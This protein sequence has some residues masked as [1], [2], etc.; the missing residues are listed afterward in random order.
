MDT[1]LDVEI[2]PDVEPEE[3][4]TKHQILAMKV[5]VAGGTRE[6][7]AIAADRH[8]RTVHRWLQEDDNFK[9]VLN[10]ALDVEMS[11][12]SRKLTTLLGDVLDLLRTQMLGGGSNLDQTLKGLNFIAK[13]VVS[14]RTHGELEERVR[15]LEESL[16]R[17]K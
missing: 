11:N 1:F 7:A 10:Q 12:A 3:V 4:L 14:F 5:L 9:R 8:V 15:V 16:F 13:H 2:A 6:A 17:G